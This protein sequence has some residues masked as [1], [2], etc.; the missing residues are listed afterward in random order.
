MNKKL[1]SAVGVALAL[2]VSAAAQAS[3]VVSINPDGPGAGTDAFGTD[4]SIAVGALDWAPGNAISVADAGSSVITPSIGHTFNTFAHARLSN[5]L[6]SGGNPIGGLNLNGGNAATN[7]E[8]TLVTGFREKFVTPTNGS[9]VAA[10]DVIGGGK[11]FFEIWYDAVPNSSNLTGLGF[12]N[13]TKILEGTVLSGHGGFVL[14]DTT[15]TAA[16]DGFLTNNYP[17]KTTVQGNGSTSLLVRVNMATIATGFFDGVLPSQLALE[18]TTEQRLN[19]NTTDPSCSFWDG[20]SD[21]GGAGPQ[22]ACTLAAT[23]GN[24]NGSPVG[25]TDK[26]V[27]FQADASNNFVPEPASL[28]LMG[29]GLSALGLSRRR[30]VL[31]V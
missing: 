10:F 21:F 8:W 5:F 15:G 14:S 24:P 20:G 23:I 29:L 2:G 25:G 17:G 16:L 1:L 31:P 27:M 19:Y 28:A 12:H 6:D 9:T 3:L 30:K 18:F 7:Y 13:G 4:S 11:N 26:N 22:G